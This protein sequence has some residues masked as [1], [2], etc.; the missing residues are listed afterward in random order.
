MQVIEPLRIHKLLIQQECGGNL[1]RVLDDSLERGRV[2]R[3]LKIENVILGQE[4]IKD[5]ALE[6]LHARAQVKC[7]QRTAA[8]APP[9]GIALVLGCSLLQYRDLRALIVRCAAES[10]IPSALVF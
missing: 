8:E 10:G 3:Y 6:E 5:V 9:T 4:Q 7:D 2:V 1:L